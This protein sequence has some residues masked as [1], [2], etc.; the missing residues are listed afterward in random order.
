MFKKVFA[1]DFMCFFQSPSEKSVRGQTTT[2][3]MRKALLKTDTNHFPFEDFPRSL[4]IVTA[5]VD[6]F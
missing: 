3:Q 1:F 4:W 2:L 6:K 5:K